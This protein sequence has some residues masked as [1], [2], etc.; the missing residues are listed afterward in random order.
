MPQTPR[1]VD[2]LITS[3]R[4]CIE[5]RDWR[6]RSGFAFGFD[7]LEVPFSVEERRPHF[8][9]TERLRLDDVWI[10]LTLARGNRQRGFLMLWVLLLMSVNIHTSQHENIK[11]LTI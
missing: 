3:H 5:G 10:D 6:E 7:V 1:A 11:Q 2:R 4:L 9:D 8:L